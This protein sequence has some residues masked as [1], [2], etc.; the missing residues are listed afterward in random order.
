MNLSNNLVAN[1]SKRLKID[2]FFLQEKYFFNANVS[3]QILSLLELKQNLALKYKIE[4]KKKSND[5]IHDFTLFYI[6]NVTFTKV[7]IM[8]HVS[9]IVGCLKWSCSSGVAKVKGKRRR[10]QKRSVLF[11]LVFLLLKNAKFLQKTPV[12][13][14]L[15]N[16]SSFRNLIVKKLKKKYFV[17]TI[18]IFNK[19]SYNGC[20]KK[21]IPRKK[22]SRKFK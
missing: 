14:H 21:K 11:K 8:I 1:V 18:K 13:L 2:T 15:N 5:L 22:F 16:V 12:A 6:I 19:I 17:K 7:K 3:N 9:D 10:K 20:R 4:N